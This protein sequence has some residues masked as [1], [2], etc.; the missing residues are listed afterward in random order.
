MGSSLCW[1]ESGGYNITTATSF[2]HARTPAIKN[3]QKVFC[4]Q[5]LATGRSLVIGNKTRNVPLSITTNSFGMSTID[6]I[7]QDH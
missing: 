1:P 2:T 6:S 5:Q 3:S 7:C 4:F